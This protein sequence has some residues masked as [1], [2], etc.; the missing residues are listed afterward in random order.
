MVH[1]NP[2]EITKAVDFTDAQIKST[3]VNYPH[4]GFDSFVSPTSQMARFLVGGKGGGRTHLMRFYSYALRKPRDG[5]VIDSIRNDGYI[6]IYFRCSGLN[7]SRFRGKNIPDEAWAAVFNFYLDVWLTEYFLVILGDIEERDG[8]WSAPAQ[9]NFV[10]T[11]VRLLSSSELADVGASFPKSVSIAD[12][13]NDLASYRKLMDRSINNAAISGR[14]D[15][16]ILANP[17]QL[18]F[19]A[20]RA[21][22]DE[23]PGLDGLLFTFLIDE[24]EN[25]SIE[26]QKYINT[27]IR[28]KELPT[29]FLVGSRRYGLRTHK[30]LNADEENKR[31]S[32]Y[33]LEDLESNYRRTEGTYVEFCFDLAIRRLR[34]AG[35]TDLLDEDDLRRIY[36]DRQPA[37]RDRL[38]DAVALSLL[39]KD[40]P[41]ARTHMRRLHTNVH[42][43]TKSL[44]IADRITKIVGRPE[45]PMSE[46]LAIHRFYQLWTR[47]GGPSVES[48]QAAAEEM[49]S[50][51]DGSASPRTNNFL[52]LWKGDLLA[53]VYLDC[54]KHAPYLGID[55][56]IELSGY[57]PRSFL[58]TMKYVTQAALLRGQEPFGSAGK[59]SVDAQVAGV[60]DASEWFLRDARPTEGLGG[61]CERAIRRLATFFNRAR[62]SDKPVEVSCVAFSTDFH[63]LPERVVEL[64]QLCASHSLLIEIPRGRATRNEG[65]V[66]HKYQLH[67]MLAPAYSLPTGRRGEVQFTSEE[68][69]AVFDTQVTDRE[70][71]SIMR[72]RLKSMDAPFKEMSPLNPQQA[73]LF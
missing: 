20:T 7:G 59:V 70:Y 47:Q 73:G 48:A 5:T 53:Q 51:R 54:D 19:T 36:P 35:F 8:S 26:Q 68:V 72:N 11:I 10:S 29:T 55:K 69:Q 9:E 22:H 67:P 65:S 18:L 56:F 1:S 28:E 40:A 14:L 62:F 50:L 57:L 45:S 34:D 32:E 4:G 52:G 37:E 42:R 44:E 43:A 21:A 71:A 31:G 27:L 66:W 15:I 25:L 60:L 2:F 24:F 12:L 64:V 16:Q 23:L 39:A 13:Q 61:E 46:K 33:E 41:D 30:T 58:T 38:G 49:D 3:F 6:G 17:G 63:D